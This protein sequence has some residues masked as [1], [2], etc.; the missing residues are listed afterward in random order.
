MVSKVAGFDLAHAIHSIIENVRSRSEMKCDGE[1]Q[2][3]PLNEA[4]IWE[5]L[6]E[7]GGGWRQLYGGY[8]DI[9]VSVEWHDFKISNPFEWSR[10]F[11]PGSL[12][13]CVNL[14]GEAVVACGRVRIQFE[15]STAGF[16]LSGEDGL[17]SWRQPGQHRFV[18][19]EFTS[20]F[21][22]THLA[23]CDGA[24]DP[25]V[26]RFTSNPGGPSGL[27]A[28]HRLNTEQEHGVMQLL[29]PPTAQGARG[30]W[31][32]GKVL[33]LMADFLFER[34]DGDELF[35]DRQKRVARERVDKVIAMLRADLTQPPDLEKLGRN[36]GCSQFHLSR[37]FSGQMG[38]T[39][40]QYLRKVRMERA[41]ELLR[42]GKYNVTEAALEVGYSSLSH[43][44]QAFCQ[45]IGCCPGLYPMK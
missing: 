37:T 42:S 40:P 2:S 6:G 32:Q 20:G 1:S 29:H 12:E 11:H 30:L 19:V 8:Y 13:L 31:Y 18:T 45:V 5:P 10:S 21:L 23:Q 4:A 36:V 17:R 27:G 14:T 9:G 43:F 35:C 38:M 15:P 44:S 28:I 3:L 39:I 24:L 33:Q 25:L 41:A 16:Y 26:E 22:N 34:R 7:E